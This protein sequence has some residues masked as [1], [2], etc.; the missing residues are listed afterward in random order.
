MQFYFA[1]E[2]ALR[3]YIT[4]V[5]AFMGHSTLLSVFFSSTSFAAPTTVSTG[6]DHTCAV[7]QLKV[8]CWGSNEDG[9]LGINA[10]LTGSITSPQDVHTKAPWNE[11]VTVCDSFFIVCT[12][13]HKETKKNPGSALHGRNVT[14]VSAGVNHTCAVADAMAFCWGDNRYG[15]LGNRKGGWLVKSYEPVE[16]VRDKDS[17]LFNKEIVD[18]T[19]G[20][21]FTCALAS[22]G[23]VACWGRDDHGQIGGNG[24]GRSTRNQSAEFVNY[25]RAVKGGALQTT[26]VKKLAELNGYTTTM[27]VITI[28]DDGVCWGR[29]DLGQAGSTSAN[30]TGY[31]MT[32]GYGYNTS[33]NRCGET[34]REA[35]ADA[36]KNYKGTIDEIRT[37]IVSNPR[38]V[39]GNLKFSSLSITTQGN[40]FQ[41]QD[42]M[43]QGET[44]SYSYA[45]GISADA[46][47]KPY[48]WGGSGQYYYKNECK[49]NKDYQD[50]QG[51]GGRAEWTKTFIEL[52][53][54]MYVRDFPGGPIYDTTS[55][56]ALQNQPLNKHAGMAFLGSNWATRKQCLSYNT[57][58]TV[59]LWT[60][61][62]ETHN[63]CEEPAPGASCATTT[64]AQAVIQCET[65]DEACTTFGSSLSRTALKL[66]GKWDQTCTP[67]GPKTVPAGSS[68]WPQGKSITDLDTG[69]SGYTCAVSAD[70]IVNC[71][72]NN[73]KGQLGTGDRKTKATPVKVNV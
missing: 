24:P 8:K 9:K 11:E 43:E 45:T 44:V 67:S 55:A 35:K 68:N 29:N 57:T 70:N 6:I 38:K 63:V 14:K 15:Q 42:F 17:A 39:T 25:P 40:M 58:T 27:C 48:Y 72:G 61:K 56:K 18:I 65:Y 59:F 52:N 47:K 49:E 5:I 73:D 26:K 3:R 28:N 21:E 54:F 13:S 64:G 51:K 19:A 66:S 62:T 37:S 2:G 31:A 46:T 16:V 20:Y 50:K 41:D 10:P 33:S 1:S 32:T 23:S 22:D 69:F 34:N 7:V 53:V 36:E 60:T 71:W 30:I 12:K 4:F